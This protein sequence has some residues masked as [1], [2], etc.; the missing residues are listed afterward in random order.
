MGIHNASASQI[1]SSCTL[2]FRSKKSKQEKMMTAFIIII[3]S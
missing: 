2:N 1:S 3:I